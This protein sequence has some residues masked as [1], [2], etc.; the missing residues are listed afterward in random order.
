[1]KRV[2]RFAAVLIGRATPPANREWVIGDTIETFERIE[3]ASGRLAAGTW[4]LGELGRVLLAAPRHWLAARTMHPRRTRAR[5]AGLM[6][7]ILQ[8]FRHGWRL[9]TRSPGFA[10][11]AITTLALG[12]GANSA[13]FAVLNAV[14]LK[15]LPFS[16]TN[17]LMLVHLRSPTRENPQVFND[18]N[19]SYLKA[20][21]FVA[22]QEVFDAT[23]LFTGRDIILSGGAEPERVR[24]EVVTEQYPALL[25]IE[26]ILGR[27]LSKDE[28][29][30]KGLSPV[31][32][33]SHALWT[34]RFGADPG[35]LGRT[36]D[37]NATPYL[38]VGV[39]PPG[40]SGLS[41][42]AEVWVPIATFGPSSLHPDSAFNHE[43]RLIARRSR[44]IP[45]PSAAAA[46]L[47][48]GARVDAAYPDVEL[49]VPWSAR[50]LSLEASRVDVDVRHG[51]IVLLAAVGC[52]LLIAGVNL[53]NLAGARAIARSREVAVRVAM[54]ASRGRIVR[55]CFAEGLLLAGAGAAAGLFVA[56][57]I[58]NAAAVLLPQ[59][60][61]FFQSSVAPGTPRTVGAAGLTRIGASMIGLDAMTIWFTV[62]IGTATAVL[63]SLLPAWRVSAVQPVEVLKAASRS[64]TERGQHAFGA[65]AVLV[66]TQIAIALVL[67]TGAG[68]MIRSAA[69]LS[70]MN[71]GVAGD[72]V[73]SIRIDVPRARYAN[74]RGAAFFAELL[75]RARHVPGVESV[76]LG[77][78]APVSG[79]CSSTSLWFPPAAFVAAKAPSVGVH[80]ITPDYI[81][82]LGLR[83]VSGRTFTDHDRIGQPK[84]ALVN[85]TAIRRFWPTVS[86]LGKT[87]AVGQ[88]GFHT[89]AEIV[90][91]VSDV[92]YRGI[93]VAPTPDVYVPLAQ[94][95]V[96]SP[97]LFVRTRLEPNALMGA[98]GR[99]VRALD[100]N[101]PLSNLKS[102]G[103]RVND[104]MWRTRVGAWLLSMFA[105]LAL[106]LAAI[107]IFGVM[108]QT[109]MQRTAEIGIR[110][111]LG[112]QRRD[113]LALV[114]RRA[115]WVTAIGIVLG[116]VVALG[117]TRLIGSLL[118]DIEPHDPVTFGAVAGLLGVIALLA[119]YVPARR[120]T[121]VDAAVAF[122]EN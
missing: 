26:P 78:C 70:H 105:V 62:G 77:S 104:A 97:Q 33:I 11:V 16:E 41:G 60:D 103:E 65:R 93:E 91:V 110:M 116:T 51:S 73:M 82:T 120:A 34:R 108:S 121:R 25:G 59:P 114:L 47:V 46:V 30:T 118:Y 28:A 58:L 18:Y 38:I 45:E 21:T 101:V 100:P 68:L 32:L 80:W 86:P 96:Y 69:R 117:V 98:I 6:P 42:N 4:L 53:A 56:L 87:I 24:A 113:V 9:I 95:V 23:A 99:E 109:V 37:I 81:R 44:E 31:A 64:A 115:A 19:W 83:L 50:A 85:E 13:M 57:A 36:I 66:C 43:Y 112:A 5:G 48:A 79:G 1:M 76:A 75:E 107:G 67:L 61:V 54:G 20:Q 90:G 122:R 102:M 39:L 106:L 55:Q 74:E 111:A 7:A 89:G 72:R 10:A 52:V 15:P 71:I 92:R 94:S 17:R 88:G 84:V 49:N 40:F 14:L 22:N 63:V 29:H 12:I 8:D 35:V 119:C 2:L 3:Q 27:T